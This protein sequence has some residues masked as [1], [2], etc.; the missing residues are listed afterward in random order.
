MKHNL[1]KAM[2]LC[3]V[4]CTLLLSASSSETEQQFPR[5]QSIIEAEAFSD[6]GIGGRIEFPE[7]LIEIHSKAFA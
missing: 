5:D 3:F 7:W 4:L 2:L 1:G 6:S